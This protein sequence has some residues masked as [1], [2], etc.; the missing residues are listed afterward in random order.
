LKWNKL[1]IITLIS[2]LILFTISG[3]G[4]ISTD[5][6]SNG[7]EQENLIQDPNQS[8]TDQQQNQVT[9]VQ[10][11]KVVA[12][13]PFDPVGYI[14]SDFKPRAKGGIYVYT[15]ETHSGAISEDFE[16]YWDEKDLLYVQLS[17]Q[18]KGYEIEPMALEKKDAKTVRLVLKVKPTDDVGKS[19]EEPARKFIRV[20]RGSL[21]GYSFEVVDEMGKPLNLQ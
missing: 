19:D 20:P 17:D 16:S 2:T 10:P 15:K 1:P 12:E 7:G 13:I 11:N 6:T 21:N 14:P 9:P 8:Q 5:D 3:C 4:F 18:Y